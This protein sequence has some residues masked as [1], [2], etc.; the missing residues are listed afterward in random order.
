MGKETFLRLK[1]YKK[2]TYGERCKTLSRLTKKNPIWKKTENLENPRVNSSLG[3]WW[4]NF[5]AILHQQSRNV[6]EHNI[7]R[8]EMLDIY[9]GF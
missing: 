8:Y 7:P 9:V 5:R 4:K 2:L 3:V 6:S 1:S